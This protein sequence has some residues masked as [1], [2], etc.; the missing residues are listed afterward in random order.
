MSADKSLDDLRLDIDKI[1]DQIH[2]LIIARTE[3]VKQV[4]EHKRGQPVKIRPAREARILYRLIERHKGPFPKQELVRIWRE[5]IVATLSFEGPFSVAVYMPESETSSGPEGD[6]RSGR[7]GM[8]RDQY[9]SF[10]PMTGH[11]SAHRVIEAVYSQEA[12]VGIMPV[13]Q[14]NEDDPWWPHLTTPGESTPKVIARLPFAGS[15]GGRSG[16]MEALVICTAIQE[17]SGRDRTYLAI[18]IFGDLSLGRLSD[19]MTEAGLPPLFTSARQNQNQ[20]DSRLYLAEV[21]GFV[22]QDDRRVKRL[23]ELLG[24]YSPRVMSIGSY[25]APLGAEDLADQ[26][27]GKG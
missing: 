1:D 4:R 12:T 27:P 14:R 26:E 16:T 24:D 22:L 9:G 8:A 3:V 7:W 19:A 21:V 20:P 11:V 18:E 23:S 10:T 25:G 15:P 2:D 17:P 6:R 13:P 5:L